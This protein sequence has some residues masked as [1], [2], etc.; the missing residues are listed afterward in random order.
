MAIDEAPLRHLCLRPHAASRPHQRA[1]PV[2]DPRTRQVVPDLRR[3][4]VTF[5]STRRTRA[6]HTHNAPDGRPVLTVIMQHGSR[7]PAVTDDDPHASAAA[8][9]LRAV[10][11][12]GFIAVTVDAYGFGSRERRQPGRLTPTRPDLMY[13]TAT[14]ASRAW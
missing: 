5:A 11:A 7:R 8:A 14:P 4:R 9:A 1:D 3:E 2:T 13:R 12:S 10:G 6:R